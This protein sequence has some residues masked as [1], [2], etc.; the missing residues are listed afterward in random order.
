MLFIPIEAGFFY[1]SI[2]PTIVGRDT[3]DVH[4]YDAFY[5]DTNAT[6]MQGTSHSS[7]WVAEDF[8]DAILDD[9][10]IPAEYVICNPDFQASY[11]S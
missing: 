6:L 1:F 7:S 9:E 3:L 11:V 10:I 2:L 4:T 5:V 8:L